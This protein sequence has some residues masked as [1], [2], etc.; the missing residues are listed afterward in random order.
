[1]ICGRV[2]RSAK[3]TPMDEGNR[4]TGRASLLRGAW[5]VAGVTCALSQPAQAQPQSTDTTIVVTAPLASD[6]IGIGD[7]PVNAQVLSGDALT[8]QHPASLADALDASLGSVS[9]S[10][11]TGSPYQS[12]VA[13]R[14][15]QATSQLGASTGLSVYF[16]GVRMN[17]PFGS[18]VNW[19]LIPMN[20]IASVELLP[21]SN[22]LFG[23][24]TLGGALVVTAK[25]GAR[26]GGLTLSAEGGSWGR[27]NFQAEGGGRIGPSLDWFVAGTDDHQRGWRQHSST[28]V[29]QLYGRLRWQGAGRH[30]ELSATWTDSQ[31]FGTQALPLSMLSTP[32]MAYSWPDNSANHQLIV[33]LKADAQVALGVKLSGNLYYRRTHE[34]ST[35]SNASLDAGCTAGGELDCA[36]AAPG[37]TARDGN[38]TNPFAAGSPAAANF[39]TYAGNLPIHDYGAIINASLVQSAVSERIFGGN[40]LVDLDQHLLGLDH[41]V[42]LGVSFEAADVGFRQTTDLAYLVAYQTVPAASNERYG[43]AGGFAGNPLMNS[44]VVASHTLSTNLFLRDLVML[45]SRLGVTASLSA[46]AT[47]VDLSGANTTFL[48]ADGGYSWVAANG[49]TFYNPAY[50]GAQYWSTSDTA[51]SALVT[52]TPPPGAIAGPSIVP[53]AGAHAYHRWNPAVGLT[54]N[55]GKAL[56]LFADYSEAL[57][58]PTAIELACANPAVPCALPTGFG[59][60]PALQAVVAKTIEAGARG[61]WQGKAGAAR[62]SWNLAIYRTQVRNDILFVYSPSG[63]GYFTNVGATE[64]KGVELGARADLSRLQLALSYG[65]VAATYRSSFVDAGGD[66]VAPGA[67][68]AGIPGHAFKLRAGYAAENWLNF[69]VNLVATASQFAHGD[70]ANRNPAV[71][72]Y[73]L[74]NLDLRATPLPGLELSLTLSNALNRRYAAYGVMGTNIY[75]AAS[76][77]FRTPAPPRAVLFG[78][79]Y[80]IGPDARHPPAQN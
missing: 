62:I 7:A 17:E 33:N 26:N 52:A 10:N 6:T 5:V 76:E 31:L 78:L 79:R 73:T 32:Q 45:T 11:G 29:H 59:G 22:P 53:L 48:G 70:E 67:R 55:P 12:D 28:N 64:R 39:L 13:Y 46:T 24:N 1:M 20:A 80:R 16:D 57:R 66:T 42:N 75:T 54:W 9:L 43:S 58:A 3:I 47:H 44:V 2:A 56:G 15:F 61:S 37:G 69:G 74:V 72:A 65:L 4:V 21:G 14:G 35:N 23:L 27:R 77:Q 63:L 34:A 50:I 36:G 41:D 51:P 60:D 38:V 19:D 68:I 30:A 49:Q 8:R 25:D 18:N 71:P 40:A